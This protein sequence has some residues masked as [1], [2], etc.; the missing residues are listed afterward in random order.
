MNSC[1]FIGRLTRDPEVKEL[2]NS[3]V[4]NFGIALNRKFKNSGGEWVEEVTFIEVEAWGKQAEIIG[5]YLTKGSKIAINA[6]VKQDT[7][8]DKDG[9]KRSKLKFR[10]NEFEFVDSKPTD[11]GTETKETKETKKSTKKVTVPETEE[12]V[13]F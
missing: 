6:S 13:P 2:T 4:A 3:T 11:D 8:D 9:N 12:H 7:W 1:T 10:V 5:Q